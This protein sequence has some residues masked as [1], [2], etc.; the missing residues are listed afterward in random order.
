MKEALQQQ[1]ED[2]DEVTLD[3]TGK[4]VVSSEAMQR[5]L[6]RN[7]ARS[8]R[9]SISLNIPAKKWLIRYRK[10]KKDDLELRNSLLILVTN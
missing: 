8:E 7:R 10:L 1:T 5:K 6:A 3:A 9:V 2:G 4:P